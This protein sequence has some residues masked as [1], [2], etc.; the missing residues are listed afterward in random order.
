MPHPKSTDGQG[1][2]N[3]K[4]SKR[5]LSKMHAKEDIVNYRPPSKPPFIVNANREGIRDQEKVDLPYVVPKPKP[6]PKSL[7]NL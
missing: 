4:V 7:Q 3:L 1:R 5:I 6:L 2:L